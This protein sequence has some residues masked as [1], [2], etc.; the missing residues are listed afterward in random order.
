[1]LVG[2]MYVCGCTGLKNV[3]KHMC[4]FEREREKGW[5][6]ERRERMGRE[7][8]GGWRERECMW[9]FFLL[10][11]FM[12]PRASPLLT[13]FLHQPLKKK[14]K[15]KSLHRTYTLFI[16]YLFTDEILLKN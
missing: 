15:K 4:V 16:Q 10:F 9:L 5:G 7:R 12:P 11:V 3:F 6:E 13:I 8:E 14:R 1:M 2:K